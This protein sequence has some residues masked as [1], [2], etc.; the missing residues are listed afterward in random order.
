[1]NGIDLHKE[2]GFGAESGT[3]GL[4]AYSVASSVYVLT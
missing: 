4:A 3:D 2:S 1:L